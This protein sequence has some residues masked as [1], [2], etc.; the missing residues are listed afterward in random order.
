MV[1][2]GIDVASVNQTI[3]IMDDQLKVINLLI[4]EPVKGLAR[5]IIKLVSDNF[6]VAIDAPRKPVR[7]K[8]RKWGRVCEVDLHKMGYRLQWTPP[9]EIVKERSD[10]QW[11]IN[12]F[13][14]FEDFEQIK[15]INTSIEIIE[16]F[17]SAC[18]GRFHNLFI[19]LPFHFFDRRSKKD[20][21]DAI[22][23]ALTA[24]CYN[25]GNYQAI[26]NVIEGQIIITIKEE[27]RT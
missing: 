4:N 12:G 21:I 10:K 24:W 20:Q 14:L 13:Q 9:L 16:T 23:C 1:Y 6:I 18:Y 2:I 17:P 3:A 27:L 15:K 7:N 8:D 26:G 22:C 5:K 11:M 19:T 25:N